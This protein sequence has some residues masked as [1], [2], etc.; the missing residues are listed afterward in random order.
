MTK[1][2]DESLSDFQVRDIND[3]INALMREKHAWERRIRELGGPNYSRGGAGVTDGQGREVPGG[4]RGYRYF[5]RAKNLPG[6][7][8]MFEA[9][10]ERGREEREAAQGGRKP[11]ELA[12]RGNMVD[13]GY[14]GWNWDESEDAGALL[15]YERAKEREAWEGMMELP[16]W[17]GEDGGGTAAPAAGGKGKRKNRDDEEW[18][19][20]PGDVGDGVAWRVPSTQEVQAE[21]VERRRRKLLDVIGE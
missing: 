5:G 12:R 15:E 20:L 4:G 18:S 10:V 3:E 7:K 2:Q 1:I 8:E 16:D 21:L 14:F 11:N 9:A 6:V 17:V 13:A 19:E